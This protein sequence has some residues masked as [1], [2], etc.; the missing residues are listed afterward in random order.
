MVKRVCFAVISLAMSL[1][2]VLPSLA[3]A[4]P[5]HM[6]HPAP[7]HMAIQAPAAVQADKEFTVKITNKRDESS[8]EGAGIYLV[9]R[10]GAFYLGPGRGYRPEGATPKSLG[11]TDAKGELKATLMDPGKYF[12]SVEK[13]GFAQAF[14]TI[15]VYK[16]AEDVT[17]AVNKQVFSQ[18]EPVTFVLKN[19][20]GS[21][22]TLSCGAPWEIVIP[23]GNS[24]FAPYSIM[25]I[26]DVEPGK[27]ITWTWDQKDHE[28][29]Q[30]KPGVYVVVLRT[31]EGPLS[32]RF[33]IT[34]LR[35]DKDLQNPDPE[36]PGDRP[37]KDVTGE[38]SWG[39]PHVLRL[40][41]R[42]IVRGKGDDTFDPQGSLT[43]A[44]FV[45][46]LLRACGLEPQGNEGDDAK[47]SEDPF[48]DVT[49]AHW[50]YAHIHR[51]REMGIVMPGE[52]PER[53]GPDVPI[54]RME[55]CVMAARAL[56]LEDE[57]CQDAGKTLEFDDRDDVAA[58]Y[59][60]YIA[61]AVNWGVLKGYTDNTFRPG[62]SAT[63]REA[64][65]IIYRLMQ[66]ELDD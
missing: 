31:S 33:C 62:N 18:A 56:G 38:Y 37:F 14:S 3:A 63:R 7:E 57:A 49:P 61:S 42:N 66:V 21:A 11:V 4:A 39:D 35:A 36:M 45:A 54:T 55:I 51:A 60:G 50:A 30:V 10:Y 40:H 43:R 48:S 41:Q 32:A 29:E 25:A 15:T 53:F 59:R 13:A 22:I 27:E 28:G 58:T 5:S 2:M 24:V 47:E 17:F 44:E 65:V 8:V 1:C 16:D 46:M 12:L 52:Y 26:I 20:T 34:G 9:P 19:G 6:S 64:A 23:N